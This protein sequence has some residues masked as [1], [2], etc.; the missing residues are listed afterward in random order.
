M[1]FMLILFSSILLTISITLLLFIYYPFGFALFNKIE[2]RKLL[3]KDSYKG[4]TVLRILGAIGIGMSLSALCLGMFFKLFN[5]PGGNYILKT[6]LSTSLI[7][8]PF[9]LFKYFKSGGDYYIRILK[10]IAVIGS[11][12]LVI[13]GF[14]SMTFTRIKYHNYPEYIKACESH[15]A[16]KEDVESA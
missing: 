10:R 9:L 13:L 7:M 1:N 11:L 12:G 2:I 6:G 8:L 3:K 15:D 5:Y 16:H 4:I 14:S